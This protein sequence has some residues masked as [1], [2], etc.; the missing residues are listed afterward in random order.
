[1]P[2]IFSIVIIF[3]LTI[4]ANLVTK[5]E[6]QHHTLFLWIIRGLTVPIF[7]FGLFFVMAAPEQIAVFQTQGGTSLDN[8]TAYGIILEAI[9]IWG[10][11]ITSRSLRLTLS[12]RIPIDPN[13][14]V[15]LL[16]LFFAGV[17]VGNV[18]MVLTQGGVESLVETG[19]SSSIFEIIW[20]QL[21][22]VAL[23]I[24][25]TG[26]FIRRDTPNLLSRLGLE[27]PTAAHLFLAL[28]WI[29]ILVVLQ[30]T[31]GTLWAL[32]DPVQAEQL[33]GLNEL[34]YTDLDTVWEWLILALAAG[35]GEELLF[36]GAMQPVFGLPVTAVLFTLGHVQYGLTPITLLILI[37]GIALGIIRNRTNTTTAIFVHTGYNF[38]LGLLSLFAQTAF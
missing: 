28:R 4:S 32:F 29:V 20:P 25:G 26:W 11:L 9:A 17:L 38:I 16:A 34:L 33:G 37:I 35:I 15:H 18:A 2:D 36:R 14:P 8:P 7:L 22:F 30:W 10:I 24:I 5:L 19:V 3:S 12:K 31:I 6:Q 21:M 1:M 13:S 27:R 23:A